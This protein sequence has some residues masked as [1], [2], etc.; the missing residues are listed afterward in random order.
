MVVSSVATCLPLRQ[1]KLPYHGARLLLPPPAWL[2]PR[3][4]KSLWLLLRK[5]Q[6]EGW[7][8]SLV[9]S[10]FGLNLK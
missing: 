8:K 10:L 9:R 1:L 3:L 7:L 6:V 4:W 2:P 5:I